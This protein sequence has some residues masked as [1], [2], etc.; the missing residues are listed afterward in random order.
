MCAGGLRS[1]SYQTLPSP[2]DRLNEMHII[3]FPA[4]ESPPLDQPIE[5]PNITEIT[6]HISNLHG[7]YPHL[8]DVFDSVTTP[9]LRRFSFT[10]CCGFENELVG[11]W[12]PSSLEKFLERSRCVL[13]DITLSGLPFSGKEV[14]S[15]LQQLPGL[16]RLTIVE[17]WALDDPLSLPEK[18]TNTFQTVTKLLISELTVQEL[19]SWPSSPLVQE[20]GWTSRFI[21]R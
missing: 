21:I 19:K 16:E 1:L 9:M 6:A 8:Q 15:I 12:H 14:T 20:T 3:T 2:N 17:P 11:G 4:I 7:A 5:C 10:G 18:I 13:T